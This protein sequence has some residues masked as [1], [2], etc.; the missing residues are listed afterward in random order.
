MSPT[1]PHSIAAT[2][3]ELAERVP[4]SELSATD[5]RA[6]L[7]DW[8]EE[9]S[10]F[11]SFLY[12][13]ALRLPEAHQQALLCVL[14]AA[15]A[16]DYAKA[17][18]SWTTNATLSLGTRALAIT[19]LDSL[20][21]ASDTSYKNALEQAEALLRELPLAD[22]APLTDEGELQS[23]WSDKVFNLPLA[24][25]QDLARELTPNY[26]HCALAV[27]R[28]LRSIAD[29]KERLA[30][31]ENLAGI[32]LAESATTLHAILAEAP[33]KASQKAIKK[34]LHRLK[35]HGVE[36]GEVQTRSRQAIGTAQHRLEQ[37]LASH[38][39][40]AGDRIILMIRT[41]SFGGYNM[42]YLVINYG[43]GIQY[44][45]GLPA[46]KRELP[47]LLA[48]AQSQA[49]F[50]ELDPAYCQFQIA[51]AHQ[52]NLDTNTPVPDEFFGLR[53]IIGES[54]T[55]VDQAIIYSTL[56]DADLQEAEAY[57]HHASDLLNLVEFGGWTLP[58]SII[59][60]YGDELHNLEESQIVVSEAI[61]RQRVGAVYERA[62]EEALGEKS[63]HLMRL[64]LEEMA[65]Y[66]LQTDRRLEALWAV[67][68]ARSLEDNNPDRLR[69]NPYQAS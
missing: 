63:R 49:P 10:D 33:D 17:L 30:L 24:L 34:A 67:A 42:A 18:E 38:I 29:A 48:K 4:T 53:D 23:P 12:R 43:N 60:K 19:V 61:Q 56:S 64:R 54:D 66:L 11:A 5:A 36:V 14:K 2:L 3:G 52:M 32:P 55:P 21:A 1:S 37:C 40:P 28:A 15:E 65:Y 69:R 58:A 35:A 27:L 25:A 47:E 41:K 31:V 20:G 57:G 13:K 9:Q 46:S 22:P 16:P 26:P 68:A 62:V 51:Q 50:I 45:A 7:N 8:L 59:Q 6:M 39:D 44:A